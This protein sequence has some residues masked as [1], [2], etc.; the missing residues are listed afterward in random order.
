M[1]FINI[2]VFVWIIIYCTI[3][4]QSQ[5]FVSAF[6]CVLLLSN[7][8]A[9]I[10]HTHCAIMGEWWL[11][12]SWNPPCTSFVPSNLF[13]QFLPHSHT[14]TTGSTVKILFDFDECPL[15]K[16]DEFIQQSNGKP[17]KAIE[18]NVNEAHTYVLSHSHTSRH[19]IEI[20]LVIVVIVF[21]LLFHVPFTFTF[22]PIH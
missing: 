19:I 7:G 8:I 2:A 3:V 9:P 18:V 4:E 5:D 6:A 20:S 15:I 21:F 1:R 12:L 22:I 14:T 11:I 17:E 10:I 16:F 13:H